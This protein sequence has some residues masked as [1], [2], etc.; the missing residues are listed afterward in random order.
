MARPVGGSRAYAAYALFLLTL[1]N[2]F[3]YA[4]RNVVFAVFESIKRD[5]DLSDQQLGWIG[6]AYI[7]VLSLAA[8]PLGVLGDLRTRRGVIAW[9]VGIWSLFTS[10]GGAVR[11]FWQLFFVRAMVGVG[12][13]GYGSVSQALIAEF[14][15]ERR[16][17][18]ALGIYSVGMALGGV[19]GVW[20]GGL[21]AE[22]YG[23]RLAFLWLG[24]P[25]FILA[26]LA[27]RLREPERRPPTPLATT[28]RRFT[29]TGVRRA[30][31]FAYPVIWL[32]TLGALASGA[33]ALIRVIPIEMVVAVFG[34]FVGVGVAWTVARLVPLAIRQGTQATEVAASAFEEFLEAAAVVLRIPTLIWVFLGG[35]LVTFAVNGLIAWAAS[36]MQRVHGFSVSDVGREFGLWGLLG[37]ALGAVVGGRLADWLAPRW[38]GARVAVAGGGFILGAPIVVVLI[39][40]PSLKFFVPCVFG[41]YFFYTWYNG[42]LSAVI[43]D[44]VPAAVRSSVMGAFLLFSHLAGDAVAPPLIGFLSDRMQST[45]H[46][47]ADDALRRAMLLL[48]AVGLVGGVVILFALRTVGR[49]MARVTRSAA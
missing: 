12:E 22:A 31:R 3:N 37:G 7:I 44:V 42:P 35:A 18:F 16:R 47:A 21:L 23:W 45:W 15:K 43:F 36:F 46:L 33:L 25:G 8:L 2:F 26:L 34:L 11:G 4:D 32:T 48:P 6:S 38:K 29:T 14:F 10:L 20:L 24:V 1:I 17:A 39:M 19:S 40:A 9:G 5:L 30:L 41:T 49:D 28:L 27:S 13:A